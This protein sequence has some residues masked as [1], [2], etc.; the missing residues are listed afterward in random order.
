MNKL[1]GKIFDY[2]T[3]MNGEFV[4]VQE[5]HIEREKEIRENKE[6]QNSKFYES[7]QKESKFMAEH[8]KRLSS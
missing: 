8:I 3:F 5:K 1:I 6:N 4:K 2:I 7:L